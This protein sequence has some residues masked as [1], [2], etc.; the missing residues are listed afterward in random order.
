MIKKYD[1]L[2]LKFC[3][4]KLIALC[5]FL[6]FS[7]TTKA[8]IY[9]VQVMPVL[10]PPYSLNTSDFYN[11][12]AEKLA[13]VLTNT[14]LQKPALSVRL[15]MYIE[16]QGAK[17]QSKDGVYYPTI[18]LDAGIP[19]RISLGELA[20][21]F[22][23]DNLSF[24]G[25]TRAMYAQKGKLPEGFYSFCFEA[26]EVN[27]GK[28]LS[29]K[30]CSMA[31]ITLS[32]PPLLNLPLKGESIASRAVQNIIFQWTPRN[33]G[34]PNGAF[35]TEYE[36][37]LKELWDTGIAAEAA[38]E[39]TQPLYQVTVRPTT[40]LMGP[41][42]PQ[43]IPGKRY[44]WR[45]RAVSTSPTGE[46]ADSYRN[47]GF[48]EI[49]WFTYQSDCKPP[50]TINSSVSSG[51]ATIN[52][53]ADPSNG[54]IPAGG[55][56]LQ[57]RERSLSG[58]KWYSLNI[59][60]N[61]AMLYDL[62]PGKTYEYRV[63]SSCVAG[64]IGIGTDLAT[65][66]DLLTLEMPGR[67]DTSTINCGMISPETTITNRT[68]IQS[69]NAGELFTAG[70][71]PVKI[72]RVSGSGSFNG[73]G[74]VTVPMLG[75]ANIKV[76]F[77][78]IQVNTERQLFAGVVE[79]SFNP[80][81][82]QIADV[83]T[84]KKDLAALG[85]AVG[86]IV[87]DIYTDIK[88]NIENDVIASKWIKEFE[89]AVDDPANKISEEDKKA[90]KEKIAD[91]SL[92][93]AAVKAV[94]QA[95]ADIASGKNDEV[96]KK[97]LVSNFTQSAASSKSGSQL[98]LEQVGN[99]YQI[100]KA[101]TFLSPAG[102]IFTLPK[103]TRIWFYCLDDSHFGNGAVYG[104]TL[105]NG[106]QYQFKP[107]DIQGGRFNGYYKVTLGKYDAEIY[108][109]DNTYKTGEQSVTY[110]HHQFT[111]EENGDDEYWFV[112]N[113]SNIQADQINVKNLNGNTI[114]LN[115][116]T[117]AN[118][119][120]KV[121]GAGNCKRND[122]KPQ[123]VNLS[124][125][126]T[127][128]IDYEEATKKWKVKVKLDA[129]LQKNEKVKQSTEAFEKQMSDLATEKLNELGGP[130]NKKTGS[131]VE[132][133]EDAGEFFVKDMNGA[134]WVKTI[135]DLGSN[136][137]ENAALPEGYWNKDKDFANS[138]IHIPPTLAGVSD[139]VINEVSDYPQL[140][141]LGYDVA[142]KPE[143]RKG[144]WTA[145]KNI[146]PG[147]VLSMAES[148]VKDKIA[149]YN[150]S[151]KPYLGY[152]EIGKDGVTVVTTMMGAGFIS[153]GKDALENGVKDTGEKIKDAIEKK[154]KDLEKDMAED[155]FKKRMTDAFERYKK[156]FT[157][158]FSEQ[159][160]Q[161]LQNAYEQRFKT[162]YKNRE[163]GKIT[164]KT[165]QELEGGVPKVF[166]FQNEVRRVDNVLGTTAKE[167]KS[168]TLKG[169]EFI[170]NQLRKDLMMLKQQGVPIERIEWHLFGGADKNMIEKLDVLRNTFG[171][172]KFDFII[173]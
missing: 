127:A 69:L 76:R 62:K 42:E 11:G 87:N 156:K 19:Q 22:N 26:I 54:G 109:D 148:G 20:P 5:S 172:D 14:D 120:A 78:N 68:S 45:V 151:D 147:S 117:D 8:Q 29:R 53:T 95:R 100:E 167:I 6:A 21:Y 1:V 41:A 128:K 160:L 92:K 101:I 13:V 138:P 89:K 150:F 111:E 161:E 47:N 97:S 50:L 124:G 27:T 61:R 116:K 16:S 103:S 51:R 141:K 30:S 152:H 77:S 49:Y 15:R 38:F 154:T 99:A 55:Y 136:V 88:T 155:W 24:S 82:E 118:V 35:N 7:L 72:T 171:K 104:F 113:T 168:G 31:Y 12:T 17:L 59:L 80:K 173:Y 66:S 65:Y 36:F 170:D 33:L 43:L 94:E 123:E 86:T 75:Y 63:G 121:K 84:I 91:G 137:W 122:N 73:E 60:E 3:I 114:E 131:T 139:G 37:T 32:D 135:C 71:F 108:T 106:N 93:A 166:K 18:T 90:I 132:E 96:I 48:S 56:S 67:S 10:V 81:E 57:Y 70:K 158:N 134:A 169:S 107:N 105:P 64:N 163:I 9:P 2:N 83:D 74:Y 46:Q 153:K 125:S 144:I 126:Y 85:K 164:E 79:T 52:W 119:F 145:V 157:E 25:I 102:K 140:V 143:V 133:T 44:A 159:E 115:Y 39:S 142:T 28:V 40:L 146:T 112:E 4:L 58:S 165:F 149:K 34:S 129:K 23:I 130:N 110:V 162:L 98:A